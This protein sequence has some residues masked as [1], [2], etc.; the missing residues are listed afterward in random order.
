MVVTSRPLTVIFDMAD[1]P[2]FC[3]IPRVYAILV[4]QDL[5]IS[6]VFTPILATILSH[7]ISFHPLESS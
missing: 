7:I 4:T 3:S 2:D 1:L 6:L 5:A